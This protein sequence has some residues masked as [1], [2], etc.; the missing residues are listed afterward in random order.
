MNTFTVVNEPVLVAAIERSRKRVAY[1]APGISAEVVE[2][3]GRLFERQ[4]SPEVTIVIDSDPEVCRLGYGTLDGLEKLRGLADLHH[5]GIRHQSGLRVAVL[6]ADDELI[7][8]AP[9]P[10][11]I[12]AGAKSGERPNAIV[13]GADAIAQ[14]LA[15]AAVEGAS[16]GLA[17][18]AEI[19]QRPVTP[20]EMDATLADLRRNPPK[21]FDV[22]RLE[23]VFNSKLQYVELKV[24][25]YKLSAR[26][27]PLPNDL[28][29][30]DDPKLEERLRNSF[31]VLGGNPLV[32]EIDS[33]DPNTGDIRLNAAGEAVREQYSEKMIE[34]DR[35]RLQ[36]HFLIQ[37]P[38]HGSL[39]LR[40]HR[41][42]F[43][44][45]VDL[46]RKKIESYH[47]ALESVLQQ[48]IDDTT[49]ELT[50]QLLSQRNGVL[51]ARLARVLT[52]A[53]PSEEEKIGILTEEIRRRI[54]NA[55]QVSK[56]E[57]KVTYKDLTYETI[58]EKTF[59][60]ALES[61]FRHAGQPQAVVAGMF[62]EYDAARETAPAK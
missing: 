31:L 14:V 42:N 62:E 7:V 26:R 57:T 33:I 60:S 32:V 12:E 6:A 48:R 24:T 58:K 8:Y 41:E 46:F 34:T 54:G 27:V 38:G 29:I 23:R 10:R 50:G 11:L 44:R 39:I 52:S 5:I 25:S 1:I 36:D 59:Q 15:A 37:V 51:P 18:T 47:S 35:K 53:Q 49:A 22:A 3:L 17:S 56:P 16:E 9:T 45:A 40:H 61:A 2:A 19:G 43:D 13:I 28:L 4:A 20:Q 30:G 21:A 55:N